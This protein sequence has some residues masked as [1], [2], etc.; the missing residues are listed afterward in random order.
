MSEPYKPKASWFAIQGEK[1]LGVSYD[2]LDCQGLVEKMLNDV[3]IF[4]NWKG[5]NHMWRDALGWKGTPE[6]CV[7][8]FG[9][10]PEG[11]WLFIV[12]N[13]GGEVARGYHDSEG[14]A[15]HV[16]VYTGKGKGAINSSAS[17]GKVCESAFA[18][19]TIK[20]GG[21]N[22]VGLCKLLQYDLEGYDMTATETDLTVRE[23]KTQYVTLLDGQKGTVNLRKTR[24]GKLLRRVPTGTALE[25]Y[26]KIGDWT[27]VICE[28]TEGW[29]MTK[30]LSDE[31][32]PEPEAVDPVV[33]KVGEEITL[34]LPVAVARALYE[35]LEKADI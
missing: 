8:K 1:Y 28:G 5:A 27:H 14:N 22:R 6:E 33:F 10:I 20:N 31:K 26:E 11:A 17:K 35:A 9:R 15:S 25:A 21:W 34:Q 23:P 29:M 7:A 2:K 32:K 13:D 16:G 3:G 19:K 4:R 18:G 24:S 12:K 30:F